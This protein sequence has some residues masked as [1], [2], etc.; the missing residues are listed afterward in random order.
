LSRAVHRHYLGP[1]SNSQ[2]R[3]GTYA[4]ACAL[5]GSDAYYESLWLQRHKLTRMPLT[6][7]WGERDPLLTA[8]YRKRW[9]DA[10]PHARLVSIEDAGHFVAEERPETLVSVLRE[11]LP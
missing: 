7:V 8:S 2:A 5:R 4:L 11:P 10:F 1:L 9:T 3:E 6:V